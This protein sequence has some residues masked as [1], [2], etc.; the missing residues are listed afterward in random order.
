[1]ILKKLILH[2]KYCSVIYRQC[3]IRVWMTAFNSCVLVLICINSFFFYWYLDCRQCLAQEPLNTVGA[4][5]RVH[6]RHF[7]MSKQELHKYNKIMMSTFQ[8]AAGLL[9][10]SHRT[11]PLLMWSVTPVLFLLWGAKMSTLRWKS[12]DIP[13]NCHKLMSLTNLDNANN[14]HWLLCGATLTKN[15]LNTIKWNKIMLM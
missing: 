6:S 10:H 4:D 14:W 9:E 7:S 1:M 5:R 13:I 11:E 15:T 3:E 12:Y 8:L 2:S